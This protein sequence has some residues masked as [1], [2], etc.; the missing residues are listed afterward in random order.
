MIPFSDSGPLS[1]L[2]EMQ[3]RLRPTVGHVPALDRSGGGVCVFFFLIYSRTGRTG[4]L[5]TLW[6]FC[7]ILGAED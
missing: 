6:V 4:L 3:V 2:C 5:G 7:S 1:A